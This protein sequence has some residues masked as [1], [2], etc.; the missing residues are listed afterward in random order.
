MFV[1][2]DGHWKLGGMETVCNFNEATPEVRAKQSAPSDAWERAPG[3]L[4][5]AIYGCEGTS[6]SS[7]LN[8]LLSMLA[9]LQL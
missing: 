9:Y 3:L 8:L 4:K 6:P 1:S 7:Y 5:L 2:E